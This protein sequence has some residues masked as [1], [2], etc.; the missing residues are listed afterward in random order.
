MAKGEITKSERVSHYEE[1]VDKASLND[2]QLLALSFKV[3]PEFFADPESRK[4]GYEISENATYHDAVTGIASL[5]IDMSVTGT[6]GRKKV[7][8]CKASYMVV[9]DNL[10]DCNEDAATAFLHRVGQ[11]ACYPYFRSLF[12]S[13]D[14]AAGLRLPPLPVHKEPPKAKRKH[15]PAARA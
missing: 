2:V 5:F 7:L 10:V 4:L 1:V 15:T 11:F 14:W 12:A 3:Q 9:Y 8:N 6:V 13:L